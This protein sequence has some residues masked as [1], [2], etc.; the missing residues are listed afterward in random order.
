MN[1]FEFNVYP[2]ITISK[3][4]V[5]AEVSIV[6]MV[7]FKSVNIAVMLFDEDGKPQKSHNLILDE[8]N[9]YELWTTD[10]W[11]INWIKTQINLI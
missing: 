4:I 6:K 1:N 9:G 8:T 10:T 11:L 2:N 3:K 5:R 7:L